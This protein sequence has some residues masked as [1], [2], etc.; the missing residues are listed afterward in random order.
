M[1]HT[2]QIFTLGG[3]QI[4]LAGQLI[5]RPP[6]RKA[7][8]IFVYLC[9]KE[10]P[11]PREILADILWENKPQTRAM[12]NLRVE[13][14]TLRK[15]FNQF[16]DIQRDS[17]ALNKNADIW[18]DAVALGNRL[19]AGDFAGAVELYRGDFLEGF[20]L[21]AAPEFEHWI[22]MQRER[23][24]LS[25]IDALQHLVNQH[26]KDENYVEG[27]RYARQL[28]EINPLM[29][30]AHRQTMRL[31]A[32]TGKR[33]AAL[34]QFEICRQ[35]LLD[36]LA[37]E[38]SEETQQLHQMISARRIDVET[39]SDRPRHNL[40]EKLTPF[41][42]REA[43]ISKIEGWLSDPTTR[44]LTLVGPGGIGKSR[45]A[46]EA[47][48][49]HLGKLKTGVFHVSLE[50][51]EKPDAIIQAVGKT[52]KLSFSQG[53]E[54]K[55]QL[56]E[57]LQE[58][59]ILLVLDNIEHSFEGA[60]FIVEILENSPNI[61]VLVT[62]REKLTLQG[63][64]VFEVQGLKLPSETVTE[65]V[66]EYSSVQLFLHGGQQVFS[67][68]NQKM[69]SLIEI[70]NI[71]RLVE[72]MPLAIELASAWTGV[73][74]P[75]E[76]RVE[77]ERN[78]DFLTTE[79]QGLPDRH[80]SMRAVFDH[81]WSHLNQEEKGVLKK[82]SVFRG[83]FTKD[84]ALSV[85]G[86]SYR[87][88]LNLINKSLVSRDGS[89]R[90]GLHELLRQYLDEKLD[91]TPAE[92][93]AA[94]DAHRRYYTTF[95][96]HLEERI[97]GGYEEEALRELENLRRSWQSAID[98]HFLPEMR[99][100]D[101]SMV[102]LYEFQG[103]Y[104]EGLDMYTQAVEELHNLED[105]TASNIS[106]TVLQIGVAWFNAR[107]GNYEK[108]KEL[109]TES[110][111]QL[112]QLA[113]MHT[114]NLTNYRTLW[115]G[116][117]L[118]W[119]YP[120]M[121]RLLQGSLDRVCD[122]GPSFVPA[123]F[124][125][126][127]ED[128]TKIR[129]H[130]EEERHIINEA[131]EIYRQIDHPRGIAAVLELLGEIAQHIGD[132]PEAKSLYQESLLQY[133]TIESQISVGDLLRRLG[134]ISFEMGDYVEALTYFNQCLEK[135]KDSGSK[136]RVGLAY[137]KL[138]NVYMEIRNFDEAKSMI[139]RSMQI[140]QETNYPEYAQDTIAV[141]AKWFNVTGKLENAAGLVA[142]AFV[143]PHTRKSARKVAKRVLADIGELD[144][145]V[146]APLEIKDPQDLSG[147]FSRLMVEV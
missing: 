40:P 68:I 131:L 133:E 79:I 82:L 29:E 116:D 147:L 95:L 104:Q 39:P 28:I 32:M 118:H 144:R 36:E 66:R 62:S 35:I 143:N 137:A 21:H 91:E 11:Q 8:A 37:D 115:L 101:L 57:L 67:K 52:L 86:T 94:R 140:F 50:G 15:H 92:K 111:S 22:V 49:K 114:L 113:T 73:L 16:L 121:E 42:G 129:G 85:T 119:E 54:V 13:L 30:S 97:A 128:F 69:D 48:R 60:P 25:V 120:R 2:L 56:L 34:K 1:E 135:Y 142:L 44:L 63:E 70:A 12:S 126:L 136:H 105:D 100:A 14:S 33:E 72:G 3:L 43:E 130:L 87:I 108:A 78:L 41:F 107:L 76:I 74:P 89:D 5:S 24:R 10:D 139:I 20:H 59:E 84:A 55:V 123:D 23:L 145:D 90:F 47:A 18:F 77:L 61:Q 9:A 53:P 141:L 98:R 88:L 122:M 71:C 106:R 80:R 96:H 103:W 7:C 125:T 109:I 65:N 127:N 112:L 4:Q 75:N 31:L 6:S 134:G 38:P 146:V 124:S 51:M 138:A 81:S 102:W 83:G 26:I 99:Y 132:L 27:L 93:D 46:I 110:Q 117:I 45:L 17:V 64:Q 58:K 19:D